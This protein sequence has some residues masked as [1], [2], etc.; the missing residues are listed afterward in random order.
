M[1]TTN[2]GSSRRVLLVVANGQTCDSTSLGIHCLNAQKMWTQH[3]LQEREAVA[4]DGQTNESR[5]STAIHAMGVWQHAAHPASHGI[6]TP[7][8]R[9][10]HHTNLVRHC[11][12]ACVAEQNI[13]QNFLGSIRG[14]SI[15]YSVLRPACKKGVLNEPVVT[16]QKKTRDGTP[17]PPVQ[18]FFAP[19]RMN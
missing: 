2:L 13:H 17:R 8:Y 6:T 14:S 3:T 7:L 11:V 18:S 4:R 9:T 5:P 1:G 19:D 12:V 10:L 15:Y 16:L